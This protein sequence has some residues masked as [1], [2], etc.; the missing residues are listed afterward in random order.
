L[1]FG[2]VL[3]LAGSLALGVPCDSMDPCTVDDI[4]LTIDCVS[5]KVI[6]VD[7]GGADPFQTRSLLRIAVRCFDSAETN[8]AQYK[9]VHDF[10]YGETKGVSNNNI[11]NMVVC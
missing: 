10:D 8:Q 9:D 7:C 6:G 4:Q 5:K 3:L 1:L 11:D 2:L